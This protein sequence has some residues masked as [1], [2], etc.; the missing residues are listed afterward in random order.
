MQEMC[1]NQAK[2]EFEKTVFLI[3]LLQ[4]YSKSQF[5]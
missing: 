2:N 3:G 1:I 4:L 5:H